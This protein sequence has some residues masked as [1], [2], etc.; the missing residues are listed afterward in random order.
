VFLPVWVVT[1]KQMQAVQNAALRLMSGAFKTSPLKPLGHICAILPMAPRL[2]K[3]SDRAAKRLRTLPPRSQPLLRMP[4][5]WSPAG[6]P[7]F[8][9]VPTKCIRGKK[10][11]LPSTQLHR[12]AT[13][14]H[15][16]GPE[17][18]RVTPFLVAPWETNL[19]QKWGERFLAGGREDINRETARA[20]HMEWWREACTDPSALV[21][22]TDGSRHEVKT[23]LP[24]PRAR[25]ARLRVE[26]RSIPIG[27]RT[28]IKVSLKTGERT[29][30]GYAIYRNGEEIATG[31]VGLGA[32]SDNYD[33]ELCALAAAA[34]RAKRLSAEDNSI[35][36]W[37]L[38]SD[39]NSAVGAIGSRAAQAGQI[40]SLSFCSSADSFLSS[41]QAHSIRVRWVPGHADIPGNERADELAKEAASLPPAIKST[42]TWLGTRAT[43]KATTTWKRDWETWARDRSWWGPGVANP[44]STKLSRFHQDFQ[45]PRGTQCRVVQCILGHCFAGEYYA[46]FVPS[47]G[48]GCKCGDPFESFN[49]VIF[50]CHAY[51][52]ARSALYHRFRFPTRRLLFGSESGLEALADFLHRCRAFTKTSPGPWPAA[53][54]DGDG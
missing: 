15:V 19:T 49:H 5:E 35:T 31:R 9:P 41:S 18:E 28:N 13:R 14:A 30:A 23:T 17:D 16:Q 3:L 43:R 11:G 42:V 47:E 24:A 6:T 32:R 22:Y 45:G 51:A 20:R 37:D 53:P 39:N 25:G 1:V 44:P 50:E 4:A 36:R 27:R 34:E 38:Y 12:L 33:G 46:R 2:D 26:G 21:I 29:G 10:A 52:G 8:L 40:F 54:D 48:R 7:D